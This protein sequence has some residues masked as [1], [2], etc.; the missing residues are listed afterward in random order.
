MGTY[1]SSLQ[2][3]PL[4]LSP[5]YAGTLTAIVGTIGSLFGIIVPKIVDVML[6]NVCPTIL[7]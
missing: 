7:Y 6:P 3:N 4:D 2:I 1:I 5:N